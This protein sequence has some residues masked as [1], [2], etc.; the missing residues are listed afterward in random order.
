[1]AV[2]EFAQQETEEKASEIN[3]V[4]LL[5]IC[6]II[7]SPHQP[8]A[9]FSQKE[10]QHLAAS[11]EEN[12]LLQPITVRKLLSG[13]YELVAGERR[14]RA[15]KYLEKKEIPGIVQDYSDERAA[16]LALIE[17]LQRRDL[18]YLEEAYGILRLIQEQGLT[19]TQISAKLGKSQ[20]AVANKLRILRFSAKVQQKLLDTGLTERHARALLL[21]LEEESQLAAIEKIAAE[22]WTVERAEQYVRALKKT[23]GKPPGGKR[24]PIIKDVRLFANS[25]NKAVKTMQEAGV[26]AQVKKKEKDGWLE[27][28]IRIPSE[29]AH[30]AKGSPKKEKTGE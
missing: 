14:L 29:S 13:R 15:Y 12:G 1:M 2:A 27:Y 19:Q 5:P 18:H 3:R 4:L 17:N 11:I 7:T 30:R 23:G 26:A 9:I 6:D 28:V 16:I 8:R 25:V 24:L 20:P 10:I 22:G 21:L